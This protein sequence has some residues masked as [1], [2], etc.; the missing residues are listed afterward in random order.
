ML[1]HLLQYLRCDLA[2][3]L[4]TANTR[5]GAAGE[6]IL[7]DEP[8]VV[9]VQ[10]GTGRI[11]SGGGAVG[12]LARQMEGRT[13]GNDR[14]RPAA[15]RRR[16]RRFPALRSDAALFFPQG[17]AARLAA[18]AARPVGRAPPHHA[19]GAAGGLQQRAAGRGGASLAHRQ[20]QGRRHRRRP[21]RGR[22]AG[23]HGLRRRRRHHGSRRPQPRRARRRPID[24]QSA[25][26][27]WTGRS[28]ITSA[29]TTASASE[30]P[31]PN[32]CGSTSA[33]PARWRRNASPRSAAWTPP[34]ACRGKP[35][36]PARKSARPWPIRWKRFSK[37]SRPR[38][39]SAV[40]TWPPTWSTTAWSFAAAARSCGGWTASSTEQTGLPVRIDP[41]P[42][43]TVARGLLICLEHLPQWQPALQSSDED[44]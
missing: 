22:A 36:S 10:H 32:G 16:D 23:Q 43:T 1:R 8:S 39:T 35:P 41:E 20:G 26:T 13:P 21:A 3:D 14:G 30:C 33:A 9:A 37:P 25:A 34:A 19:G 27:T 18:E 42:L 12:H 17:A 11:L 6:G 38:S 7:L 2:I 15:G 24:P 44:V 28:S 40:P 29:A 31:P 5:I 4:G